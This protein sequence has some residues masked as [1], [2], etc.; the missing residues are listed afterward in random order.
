MTNDER[1][2]L[3]QGI[4]SKLDILITAHA[5]ADEKVRRHDK[6]LYDD[7]HGLCTRLQTIEDKHKNDR[8]QFAAVLSLITAISS[9]AGVIYLI[10]R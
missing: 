8:S 7:T 1:D 2:C 3:I 10:I 5:V 9:M 4:S 6:T